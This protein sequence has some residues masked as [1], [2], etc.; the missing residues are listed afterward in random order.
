M[1]CEPSF[2]QLLTVLLASQPTVLAPLCTNHPLPASTLTSASTLLPHLAS[3]PS[4]SVSTIPSTLSSGLASPLSALCQW[5]EKYPTSFVLSQ[6]LHERE[7]Q[8]AVIQRLE[9]KYNSGAAAHHIPH[10]R[11]E[12]RKYSSGAVTEEWL[13]FYV[14]KKGLTVAE[15]WTEWT[16]GLEG[17]FS[18]RD[19]ND[20]WDARWRRNNA[21]QKTENARR[22]KVVALIEALGNQPDW[23]TSLA[24]RFLN[25]KYK[26]PTPSAPHLRS[27]RA[28]IDY[29]QDKQSDALS[30]ILA[31]ASLY[32]TKSM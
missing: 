25:N 24:L 3:P 26:I 12:W 32:H 31:T 5:A 6:D 18:I 8:E 20:G 22:R 15:I 16:V 2:V 13:P 10:H 7:Q 14:F 19:L 29:L 27:T 1:I 30:S 28:F 4:P 9:L 21:G 23:S 11:F 17:C